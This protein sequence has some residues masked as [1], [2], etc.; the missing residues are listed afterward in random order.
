MIGDISSASSLELPMKRLALALCLLASPLTAHAG[1]VTVDPADPVN[2]FH[3]QL[4]ENPVTAIDW[5]LM[6]PGMFPGDP[7]VGTL[8][9]RPNMELWMRR[10]EGFFMVW[11]PAIEK[12][13]VLYPSDAERGC[14]H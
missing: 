11:D 6:R 4:S 2:W 12:L 14:R 8:D 1:A 13:L 10:A 7:N 9:L 5:K 3:I